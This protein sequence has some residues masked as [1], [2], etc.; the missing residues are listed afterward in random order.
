MHHVLQYHSLAEMTQLFNLGLSADQ[1][2]L[3]II[4]HTFSWTYQDCKRW[5]ELSCHFWTL[6]ELKLFQGRLL[7][8]LFGVSFPCLSTPP[9]WMNSSSFVW[10]VSSWRV[11][12]SKSLDSPRNATC[13]WPAIHPDSCSNLLCLL[14]L[15]KSTTTPG[16]RS[17]E[18]GS[19]LLALWHD[20]PAE[21]V[22]FSILI[23]HLPKIPHHS[24][25]V[26]LCL[27][28]FLFTI[29]GFIF[30]Y[31]HILFTD[32]SCRVI[33][34]REKKH[35]RGMSWS[36]V[37]PSPSLIEELAECKESCPRIICRIH[38]SCILN[39]WKKTQAGNCS[40][41]CWKHHNMFRILQRH[42][43]WH[44]GKSEGKTHPMVFVH[45]IYVFVVNKKSSVEI[46]CFTAWSDGFSLFP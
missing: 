16:I 15:H 10:K 36:K 24:I 46:P 35:L 40:N 45:F 37:H 7:K 29:R 1:Q 20:T 42:S 4:K 19:N 2:R 41:C 11:T 38:M 43:A 44:F 23:P 9:R 3:A 30:I 5:K 34:L 25:E 6:L 22:S 32:P 14:L 13:I 18:S 12:L 26:Y 28:K 8:R 21:H 17:K 27:F 39:P 33:K 31:I